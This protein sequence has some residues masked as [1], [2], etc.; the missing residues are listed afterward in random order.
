MVIKDT[1]ENHFVPF[2]TL[3]NGTVFIFNDIFYM[4]IEEVATLDVIDN[5]GGVDYWFNAVRLSDGGVAS[6][7]AETMVFKVDAE[8]I[9]K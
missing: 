9:V 3:K 1:R 4:V 8:L 2:R 7:K 5:E 6:F